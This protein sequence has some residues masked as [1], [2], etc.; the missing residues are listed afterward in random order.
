M[1]RWSA[2]LIR[3][4]INSSGA[5]SSVVISTHREHLI[6]AIEDYE[7][8]RAPSKLYEFLWDEKLD[9]V[10]REAFDEEACCLNSK[11]DKE[12]S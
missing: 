9:N 6:S 1:K 7:L 12:D 3:Y 2:V 10:V 5:V 11:S 4:P 8:R